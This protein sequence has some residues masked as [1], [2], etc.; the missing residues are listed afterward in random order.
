[1]SYEERERKKNIL[2]IITIKEKMLNHLIVL[3]N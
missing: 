3:K 1:M 2:Q